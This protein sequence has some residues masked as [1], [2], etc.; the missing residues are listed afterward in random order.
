MSGFG[1]NNSEIYYLTAFDNHLYASTV[2]LV[3]GFE[4]WKT[5]ERAMRELEA[6]SGCASSG[7]ASGIPGINTA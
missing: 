2:N 5:M 4:V 7:T 6:M 3:T 1:G